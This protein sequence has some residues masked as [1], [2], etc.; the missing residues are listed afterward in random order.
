MTDELKIKLANLAGAFF[1]I[2]TFIGYIILVGPLGKKRAS[3]DTFYYRQFIGN[4]ILGFILSYI[5]RYLGQGAFSVAGL[6][7]L[8]LIFL[9]CY[10]IIQDNK[11]PLPI[12]GKYFNQYLNFI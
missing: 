2:G 1:P 8:A 4:I 3:Y 10:N 12:V 9:N 6:I 11:T 7:T 5:S